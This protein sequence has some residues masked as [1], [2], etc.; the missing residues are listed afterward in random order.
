M[1]NK[2]IK[3]IIYYF[4]HVHIQ[5]KTLTKFRHILNFCVDGQ[6][7]R[8]LIYSK[9]HVCER[10][11]FKLHDASLTHERFLPHTYKSEF[12]IV[13]ANLQL[14]IRL[15]LAKDKT[16]LLSFFFDDLTKA[17]NLD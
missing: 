5:K 10:F 16:T 6:S 7:S 12:R 3:I 4:V 14:A 13:C 17:L 2:K 8:L 11:L 15:N 9:L 1:L